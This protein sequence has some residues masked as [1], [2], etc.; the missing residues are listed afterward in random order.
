MSSAGPDGID[1][2]LPQADRSQDWSDVRALVLGIGL[3]GFA[4][5]DALLRVGAQVTV[6]DIADGPTQLERGQVLE[7][8][9]AHTMLGPGAHPSGAVDLLVP[10]PGFPPTH[11]WVES[12]PARHIWSG[13][14]LAWQLR[15]TQQPAP[16][17]TVTG[18]NGKTTTVEMLAAILR[19]DGRH[20][21]AVGNVGRPLVEAMF[22]EPAYE[23]LAVELSSFQL[24]WTHRIH[25]HSAALLNVAPDHI[26]WHGSFDEY[27][28]DKAKIFDGT[29]HAVVYN[30]ADPATEV[31]A[32]GADIMPGCHVVG[33][34]LDAPDAGML[35]V[36]DGMLVDRAFLPD[37]QTHTAELIAVEDLV[38]LGRHN[39]ENAL[40]AS[41]M[42]RSFGIAAAS[43]RAG[44]AGFR[45]E[46]HRLQQ[47]GE[48]AG[49]RYVDD[50]KATNPL[51]ASV[52]LDAFD[53]VVWIAGGIDKQARFDDL[54]ARNRERLAAVVLLGHDHQRLLNT[55][56]RHA[57]HVP[58][59]AVPASETDPM[60]RAVAEAAR[61]A[62]PGDCV[63]LS[64]ACASMDQ[65]ADY[66]G[67]GDAFQ[68]AVRRLEP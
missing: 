30:A 50:S 2:W 10:S 61:L 3:S 59:F 52:A 6:V 48:L 67:R 34:T 21:A 62:R 8:L 22:S 60:T 31:A 23:V 27:R 46:A 11:K 37:R 49:V 39:I 38:V 35:G 47:V 4:A 42:A 63:L 19:A 5:A 24:H 33:T 54:V 40:V 57:P 13:E 66:A 58:V 68:A 53:R 7:A 29:V 15:P 56:E 65:F 64:P 12:A 20:A 25:A 14:Q 16:W 43:V 41:A 55:I 26:D 9:G 44:L 17:L 1:D 28:R 36:V 32:R 18:T 51:A 45:P